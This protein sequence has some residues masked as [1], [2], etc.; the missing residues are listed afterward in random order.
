MRRDG[1]VDPAVV[2]A[3]SDA[4]ERRSGRAEGQRG[5][6]VGKNGRRTPVRPSEV[7]RRE[8]RLTVTFSSP[9]I[10]ERLR[11]LARAWGWVAPDGKSPAVSRVV[12]F[13]L[14]PGLQEEAAAAGLGSVQSE[15]D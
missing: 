9:D 12:E 14:V 6:G 3:L 10:P 13:L 15:F 7:R 4:E 2:A 8:R 5:G 11:A 1:E